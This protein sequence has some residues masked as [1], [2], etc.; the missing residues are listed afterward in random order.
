MASNAFFMSRLTLGVVLF[1]N[2]LVLLEISKD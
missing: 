2:V 1:L